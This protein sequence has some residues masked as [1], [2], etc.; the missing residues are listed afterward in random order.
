MT[1]DLDGILVVSL[2]HA[3]AAPFCAA[4]LA[5]AGARVVKVER[6]EGD[7]ARGYD[8][9]VKGGSAY[10]VWLNRGKES[11]VLD[12]KTAADAALLAR[13]VAQA[14]VFVQNM[15]PGRAKRLGF[16]SADLRAR[17]PRLITCD[18]SGY[19]EV[20]PY[21][22][23]KAYDLLVQAETG[24]CSI[25]GAPAA[26]G[27]VGISLADV[28]AGATAYGAI[29]RA[30]YRRERTGN[31]AALKTSLFDT[32]A[33]WMSVPLLHQVYGGTAPARVGIRHPS[34][35]P[36]GAFTLADGSQIVISVQNER[37]WVRFC[38]AILEAPDLAADPRFN[39]MPARVANRDALDARIGETFATMDRHKAAER[40][41]AAAIA[42]GMLNSVAD[43]ARHP[44]LKRVPV[45]TPDGHVDLVAPPVQVDAQTAAPGPVPALG[46]HTAAIRE[47]FGD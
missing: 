42:Y 36:Y 4:Q 11:V 43:F 23:M 7:F 45:E 9:V 17:H 33:D 10:F 46:E 24:L 28:A 37:E 6:P 2:E 47:E 27:R 34:I 26:P 14:D 15:G 39:T 41:G 5:D 29:T 1:G 35:A 32:L 21:A 22:E 19:G 18:I 3:V 38:A 13:I 12:L 44:Q 30:L 40:L 31:G 16:G 25:T 20:G 8:S